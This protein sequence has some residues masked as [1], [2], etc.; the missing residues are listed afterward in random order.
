MVRWLARRTERVGEGYTSPNVLRPP[1]QM[2][3]TP[4]SLATFPGLPL[5]FPP[6]PYDEPIST[7]FFPCASQ[8]AKAISGI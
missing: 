1:P 3:Y 7:E 8:A 6:L 5:L 4:E 2:L